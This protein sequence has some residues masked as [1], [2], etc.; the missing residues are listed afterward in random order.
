MVEVKTVCGNPVCKNKENVWRSQPTISN[1]KMDL[2]P[3]PDDILENVECSCKSGCSTNR[4]SCF[5]GILSCTSLCKCSG[6]TN[7]TD[8]AASDSEHEDSEHED[9]ESDVTDIEGDFD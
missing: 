6:C 2:L 9:S 3:A 5:K 8:L 4:C 7:S 1:T